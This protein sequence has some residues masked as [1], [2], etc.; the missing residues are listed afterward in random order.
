MNHTHATTREM[1]QCIQNCSDCHTIC[2]ATV[3]HCLDM[4]GQHAARGHITTLLDCAQ[5][6]HTSADFMLRG[7]RLHTRT[8]AVCAEIC[9]QCARECEA[10]A[11]DDPMMTQCAE[12]CRRCADSCRQM[13][14]MRM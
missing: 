10:L 2:T 1:Q 7:S 11:G 4:G 12:T 13:S 3:M 5:I 14:A 6:C 8:C 9:D